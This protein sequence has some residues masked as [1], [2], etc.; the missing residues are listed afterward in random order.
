M[1]P[2]FSTDAL[3]FFKIV[4]TMPRFVKDDVW[5]PEYFRRVDRICT[6]LLRKEGM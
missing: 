3:W 5:D 4:D 1:S 6:Y 2:N